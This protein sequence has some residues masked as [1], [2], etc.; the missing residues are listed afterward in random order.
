MLYVK[1]GKNRLLV[2][3]KSFENFNGRWIHVYLLELTYEPNQLSWGKMC[4]CMG[5][6]VIS[7]QK[8]AYSNIL[9]I[10]PP[11]K[12]KISDKNFCYFS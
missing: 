3:S 10:L 6:G 9:K 7:I 4:V 12:G 8:H 5:G 1:Y 11:K 2:L